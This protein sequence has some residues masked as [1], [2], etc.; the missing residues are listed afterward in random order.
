[1]VTETYQLALLG[2]RKAAQRISFGYQT[3]DCL[4]RGEGQPFCL[5]VGTMVRLS[6]VT[7]ELKVGFW[8]RY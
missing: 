3:F 8:L 5:L 2:I 1:M 4:Y 6:L 7:H